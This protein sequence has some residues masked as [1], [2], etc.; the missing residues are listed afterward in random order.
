MIGYNINDQDLSRTIQMKSN[1]IFTL[2]D[3]Q[4]IIHIWL[5]IFLA[6]FSYPKTLIKKTKFWS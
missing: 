3:Q 2:D 6:S 4:I 5:D 1:F